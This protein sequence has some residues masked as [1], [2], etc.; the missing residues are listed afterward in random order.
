MSVFKKS[1][2]PIAV[3][4]ISA[5]GCD[6]CAQTPVDGGFVFPAAQEGVA[7]KAAFRA[8]ASTDTMRLGYCVDE[9]RLPGLMLQDDGLPH[10]VGAAIELDANL[11]DKYVGDQIEAV[12]FAIDPARGFSCQVFVCTD[13]KQMQGSLGGGS[14]LSSVTLSSG[15]YHSGWNHVKLSKPVTIKEGMT[16][17][18]GY[19]IQ[20]N[21]GPYDFLLFD[22][23]T[24]AVGKKNW[25][26][27]NG[28]WFNNTVGINRNLCVRAVITGD[29]KPQNDISLMSL[30]P[31]DASGYSTQNIPK[32]YIAY[33]QNNGTDPIESLS[34]I[35]EAKGLRTAEF[36]TD[37]LSV[38]N[39]KPTQVRL[40][41]ISLPFEGNYNGT[42]TVAE[43]NGDL[44]PDMKDNV[45]TL[46]N[47][48]SIKEGAKAET[49]RPLF[50][51]FTSEG[52]EGSY[53][54][55]TLYRNALAELG[56]VIWVKH[57]DDYQKNVDQFKFGNEADYE[58]LY[59]GYPTFVPAVCFDRRR[60]TGFEEPGPAYFSPYREETTAIL[61]QLGETL[62]FI[63]L[64]IQPT[65]QA[66]TGKLEV[67]IKGHAGVN[68]MPLQNSLRMTTWLV[69][70]SIPTT[71]QKG[72]PEPQF[73]QNGVIR[74]VL[75]EEGIW[76]DPIDIINYDFERSYTA[77]LDPSWN[78]KHLRVVSF[79]SNWDENNVRN[80]SVYNTNQAPVLDLTAIA[81]LA[82]EPLQPRVE[83][84]G[85][86][87]ATT[88]G[89]RIVGVYD[90]SGREVSA[91]Q[92]SKGVYIVKVT[93]GSVTATQKVFIP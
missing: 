43:V 52:Y 49:H 37:G 47:Y 17:Y 60:I 87:L 56:D 63:D 78:R 21:Q 7:P 32:D 68:E 48:Y 6:L 53:I 29:T 18:V 71:T 77:D 22:Q 66:A 57:H 34:I 90:M 65:I 20:G 1:I 40:R 91:T 59:G 55:D 13:L 81:D 26:G 62:T 42:F 67:R 50:E 51:E 9:P 28:T 72:C 36:L 44:D 88:N 41:D 74:A 12:E 84:L 89:A 23:S 27:D 39:N 2:S 45:I 8:S 14:I 70:D 15:Q 25:Y 61:A 58:A 11:L 83:V 35:V 30:A 79:V 86:T 24:Y 64:D 76:G 5:A 93:N 54:A 10:A 38:P 80:R 75:S 85:S 73:I 4:L 46:Y 3:A 31:A 16:L 33:I 92:L 82:T 19:N 69:E